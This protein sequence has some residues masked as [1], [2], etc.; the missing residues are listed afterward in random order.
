MTIDESDARR[1]AMSLPERAERPCVVSIEH[2]SKTY[3]TPL[4]RLKQ[5]LRRPIKPPIEAL[6]DVSFDVLEGEGEIFGLI[7]RN[8]AGKM[9]LTKI[10]ATLVQPTGGSV[11]VRGY[12]SVRDDERVR[13][14]NPRSAFYNPQST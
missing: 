11:T 5:F 14:T 6:H 8:G 4:L 9:I 12:D 1:A 3:P 10:V 13:F 2:L 7:G